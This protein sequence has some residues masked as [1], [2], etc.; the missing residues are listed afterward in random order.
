MKKAGIWI[1]AFFLILSLISILLF[2]N[3]KNNQFYPEEIIARA[4][5]TFK[6]DLKNFLSEVNQT[7]KQLEQDAESEDVDSLPLENLNQYFS[8]IITEND[9]LKGVVVFGSNMN[10]VIIRDNDSWVIAHNTLL[11]SLVNWKRYDK[12]LQFIREWTDTYNFFMDQK[13]FNSINIKSLK[14]GD[15]V[16][17]AAQSQLPERREL[18]FNIFKLQSR[19]DS[20]IVALMFKT[21]DLSNR[22]Y[23]VLIFENP[24]VTIQTTTNELV[25]PIKTSDEKIISKYDTLRKTIEKLFFTWEKN[26]SPGSYSYSSQMGHKIYWTNIDSIQTQLGVKA[27]AITVSEQDLYQTRQKAEQ[28]YLYAAIMFV[29]FAL[30]VYLSMVRKKKTGNGSKPVSL[31]PLSDEKIKDLISKGETEFVEFKSSLRWDYREEKVNKSLEE[32]VLKGIAAFSNAKGGTLIIGV[33]DDLEIVGLEPDFNTFKKQTADYFELHLRKLINNRYGIKFSNRHVLMQFPVIDDKIICVIR[34]SA[35][36][37]P[38]YLKTKN[39]QGQEVEIFYVRSGN[40]SHEITSLKEIHEYIKQRF[41][42]GD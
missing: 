13:N 3:R 9:L 23:H 15:Y 31:S 26:P 41:Q 10:Y 30:F 40:A 24:L 1:T 18:L 35:G 25:T 22:F 38:L 2:F 19:Q 28:A 12:K 21:N 33:N 27:F 8:K 16:W 17:R 11:D 34:I 4:S 7:V 5:R 14:S 29:L 32:V 6:P 37:S 42:E 20:D 36:T 39:K